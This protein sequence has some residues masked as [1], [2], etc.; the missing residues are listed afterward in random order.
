MQFLTFF[1]PFYLLVTFS[2]LDDEPEKATKPSGYTQTEDDD[3]DDLFDKQGI[4]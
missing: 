3:L 4:V 2:A 1:F